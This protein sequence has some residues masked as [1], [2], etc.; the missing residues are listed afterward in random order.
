M[1]WNKF[2]INTTTQAEDI[3]SAM[4]SELG[5]EGV[6]I[7]D[8]VPLTDEEIGDMFI[9]F[10]AELPPDDGT[11][12]VSF[13][14]KEGDPYEEL[15]IKV[16]E[17]LE[18]EREFMDIGEGT[19]ETDMTED[20]D[21]INNWKKFF[22]AFYI[23][24]IRIIPTWEMM[25]PEDRG[26]TI[27]RIDPGM[28]FGTGKHETTRLVIEQMQK[29]L[30]DGDRVL[31]LGFGSGILTLTA[32]KLGAGRVVGTDVDSACIQSARG[33][34]A[35]NGLLYAD[36]EF[37]I[38]N[39]IDDKELQEKLGTG[40]YD[41]VLA[42]IL[43]DIIIP[44]APHIYPTVKKGGTLITSG[45]IDFKENDVKEALEAAGFEIIEIN[46]LGEWV[47]INARKN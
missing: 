41:V 2:T 20:I 39:L 45:I 8:N 19:I 40:E 3:I 26:K 47:N 11:S 5:V 21:W 30:K 35:V 38:G 24:D 13:C 31:D 32:I 1:R 33:N 17:A 15:L 25:K 12:K 4:L 28:S 29:Y 16:R 14:V 7:E 10:P 36:T 42:N 9:D 43:A 34:L 46:H 37:I 27:I 44:M 23:G 22:T 18:A 6:L